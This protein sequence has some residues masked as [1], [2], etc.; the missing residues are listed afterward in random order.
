MSTLQQAKQL[1]AA[2]VVLY[3]P[4][5]GVAD[6]LASYANAVGRLYVVDNSETPDEAVLQGIA[7][8]FPGARLVRNRA[9]LGIARALNIGAEAA[10]AEGFAWLLTMD[11]DS[12]AAADMV[13]RLLAYATGHNP[14]GR[15]GIVAPWY[16]DQ[17]T[18]EP[19]AQGPD[20]QEVPSVITSGNLLSLAAYRQVGPFDDKLFIDYVDHEYCLRLRKNGFRIV[21]VFAARLHH[22]QGNIQS[23]K[24]LN[25]HVFFSN[26]S[27]TRRY[28]MTRNRLY[29]LQ[30]YGHLFP[31]F[32]RLEIPAIL[33]E[34]VKI[35]FF[36]GDKVAKLQH[37]WKGYVHFKQKR[38]GKL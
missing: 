31:E 26:H 12:R 14:D 15:T 33:K 35:V 25:H 16:L 2:V 3:R 20:W 32:R 24:V 22:R 7:E 34:F 27:A 9:N 37:A 6:L 10:Q 13:P 29:V 19:P 28:Y 30:A 4:D 8:R 11:Q 18:T 17:N 23:R 38:F 21:Q 36:E 1:V 5:A